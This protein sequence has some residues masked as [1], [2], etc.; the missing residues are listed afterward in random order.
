MEAQLT[1]LTHFG[2]QVGEIRCSGL[3]THYQAGE[4]QSATCSMGYVYICGKFVAVIFWI[5]DPV[6]LRQKFAW[7]KQQRLGG[8]GPFV[9]R[10]LDPIHQPELSREMWSTFD[11][12]LFPESPVELPEEA[13]PLRDLAKEDVSEDPTMMW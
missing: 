5:D 12:F 11:A 2:P 6:L 10:N 1:T 7:A 4:D 8:V 3:S 9:F 13:S